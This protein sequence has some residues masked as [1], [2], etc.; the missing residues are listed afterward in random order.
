MEK[1]C[2]S[3]E[4]KSGGGEAKTPPQPKDE[5]KAAAGAASV[6]SSPSHSTEDLLMGGEPGWVAEYGTEY[7]DQT[8]HSGGGNAISRQI[9][10][11]ETFQEVE[12]ACGT[13]CTTACMNLCNVEDTAERY[14]MRTRQEAE[15]EARYEA[16]RERAQL[17]RTVRHQ[18]RVL[19]NNV[20]P[21]NILAEL[22]RLNQENR[23]RGGAR[24]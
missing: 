18:A 4:S 9:V 2:Q 23:Y 11:N 21:A 20:N 7:T 24:N 14:E 15:R 3:T 16:D 17:E 6:D 22:D 10:G 19:A 5:A 1:V 12:R 13:G 8:A